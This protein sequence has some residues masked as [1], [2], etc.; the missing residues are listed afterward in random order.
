MSK[1]SSQSKRVLVFNPLK[2]LI[3]IYQSAFAASRSFGV[4]RPSIASVCTGISMSCKG[5]YFRYLQDDIEVTFE[6]LGT[7][8]L[9]E[10]DQLCGVKRQLY[11]TKNMSRKGTKYKTKNKRSYESTDCKQVKA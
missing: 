10:Y 7:L 11:K 1:I 9:E 8:R 5:M 2:K 6:D 3:A 4:Q